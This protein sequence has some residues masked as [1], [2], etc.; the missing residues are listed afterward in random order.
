MT[1]T[2]GGWTI[3][4]ERDSEYSGRVLIGA[5]GANSGIGKKLAGALPPSDMEVAFG[6]RAPLP[7][8]GEAPTVVA[9][10]PKWVGYAW[11]F[12]RP[13]HFIWYRY[14]SRCV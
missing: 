7:A 9:F 14:N 11:A 13:D 4:A 6:Y 12:P 1:R 3:V 5:D 10:L 2:H 8:N